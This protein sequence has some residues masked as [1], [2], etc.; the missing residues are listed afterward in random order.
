MFRDTIHSRFDGVFSS[1]PQHTPTNGEPDGPL[2]GNGD[3]GLTFGLHDGMLMGFIGKNDMWCALPSQL[4]GGVKTVAAF[5]MA[6]SHL[7][8]ANFSAR[9]AIMSAD[10]EL[11]LKT[12]EC[13]VR[14]DSYVPYT[15]NAIILQLTCEEGSTF[16]RT[17]LFAHDFEKCM[18][19]RATT[20]TQAFIEKTYDG[21][22]YA[23]A[24]SAAVRMSRADGGKLC[25]PIQR[26][27]V[28]SFIITVLTN[29]DEH[30]SASKDGL[31]LA[32]IREAHLDFWKAFWSKSRIRIPDEPTIEKYWYG[33][34]YIMACSAKK[35]C[36]A[37]G[38]FGP[39]V[40]TDH[41]DWGSDY[42]LNYNYQA[43]WWGVFSSNHVELADPYDKPLLDYIPQSQRNARELLG[44][45]GL[46]SVV[47]IGPE[48]YECSA[49]FRKDG[50]PDK[51]LPFWGQKSNAVY[52]AVNML[53]RF[54]ATFD[55][56]YARKN[57]Y[58]YCKEAA[59][60]WED[61][62]KWDGKR[63][64]IENDCIHEN[65]ALAS[66]AGLWNS[67]EPDYSDDFNPIVSLGLVRM[68]MRGMLIMS[69]ALNV[70]SSRREKWQHI[71]DNL[72]EYPTQLRNGKR[73]F[74]YTEKGRAWCDSNSLGIQHIYPA[75]G[76]GLSSDEEALQIARNTLDEL[77]RWE[78]YNAFPTF[79]TA[80]CFLG[81]DPDELL[82]RLNRE[83]RVHGFDNLFIYYGGGGLECASTV[84][85]TINN[86]LLQSH[87]D[88]IRIFP[89]WNRN[90]PASFENLRADGAFIVSG[91]IKDAKIEPIT[92][93]SERGRFLRVLCPWESGMS[94]IC[95][96]N[97]LA[98][99]LEH[100]RDGDVYSLPTQ[101]GAK[102]ILKE[103][104]QNNA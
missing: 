87:E 18:I 69:E 82:R 36:F 34:Q 60:F 39:F 103:T 80:A 19:Q 9:E 77:S 84:S 32:A 16:V 71:L 66:R 104:L 63:Y 22:D 79:F 49:M 81:Y 5:T 50:T 2:T 20:E 100:V 8:N 86:M 25:F 92:I 97:T 12:D 7:E 59:D 6:F 76:I 62:L 95:D 14:V 70:D 52:A 10:I 57:A 35:G 75:R 24:T 46:Y 94:I 51:E 38:I 55:L 43:P 15:E 40:T 56:D 102:Y 42:H 88:F 13:T 89:V 101:I 31:D 37:P 65:G 26:G 29:H 48:G 21:S 28:I 27:D 17:G 3:I 54:Y 98:C 4:G 33:S 73:V 23:F 85:S 64:V 41:A 61:Y 67:H 44:C 96:G 78:D 30:N 83:L 1:V 45:R 74:R 99:D 47:G 53:M 72:S 91:S 68:L 90:T 58:P 93:V 11:T